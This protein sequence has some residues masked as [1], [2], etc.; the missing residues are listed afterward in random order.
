VLNCPSV[1]GWQTRR[2]FRTFPV[3][4]CSTDDDNQFCAA[5]SELKV[6]ARLSSRETVSIVAVDIATSRFAPGTI[7][8][9][10][11][12][13][14]QAKTARL[15]KVYRH[16]ANIAVRPNQGIGRKK[17][18]FGRRRAV[19]IVSRRFFSS[20]GAA[21]LFFSNSPILVVVRFGWVKTPRSQP[22]RGKQI[23]DV[24]VFQKNLRLLCQ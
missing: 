19:L 5:G 20:I 16:L 15:N 23:G 1:R 21:S 2:R 17:A 12:K 8:G 14:R 18:R 10:R 13:F 24:R 7:S 4:R 6:S 11:A 9:I 22:R 3:R